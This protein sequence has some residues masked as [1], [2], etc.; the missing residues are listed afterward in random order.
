MQIRR[1]CPEDFQAVWELH[2]L[3]MQQVGAHPGR[4]PWDDDLLNI[5][6]I[7]FNHGGD[8]LVGTFNDQVIAMG[9]LRKISDERAEIKK[10]RVHPRFRGK[11][12]G[13]MILTELETRAKELGFKTLQLDTTSDQTAAQN[14]YKKNGFREICRTV[15]AALRSPFFPLR[16]VSCFTQSPL[17]YTPQI[18]P[19]HRF[20]C[21]HQGHGMSVAEVFLD[22]SRFIP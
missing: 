20:C 11:G 1:Y 16:F 5:E 19:L 7:Y 12:Y 17:H 4:S 2:S 22:L 6:K 18:N 15:M 13:Q 14:L 8:F 21:D 10:M 9:A 3:A